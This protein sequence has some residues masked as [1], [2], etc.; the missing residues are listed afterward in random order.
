MK[1]TLFIFLV[2]LMA[3]AACDSNGDEPGKGKLPR[4][5]MEIYTGKQYLI[6]DN[7]GK[8]VYE[9]P[10]TYGIVN[11]TAEGKNWYGVLLSNSDSVYRVLKNGKPVFTTPYE[12]KSL[13][14][15]NGDI[16]T[17]QWDK[18][19]DFKYTEHYT[20]RIFKNESQLYEYDSEE[21][22]IYDLSVDHGDLIA[23]AWYYGKY[24]KPT[25]WINGN[26]YTLPINKDY[27]PI[28]HIVKNGKDT[29]AI[30][31]GYSNE[32]LYW[33]MNGETHP[34]PNGFSFYTGVHFTYPGQQIALV[35]GVP[36]MVG[37]INNKGLTMM[38]NGQEYQLNTQYYNVVRKVQRLGSDVYTLTTR[39]DYFPPDGNTRIFKGAEQIEI[40]S[41]VYIPN[42]RYPGNGCIYNQGGDTVKLTDFS[43][44]D[45]AVLDR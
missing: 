19:P 31:G 12:V 11:M 26:M 45:F 41:K 2:A 15:E 22:C 20:A 38:I 17:L 14:V 33:W 9:C 32:P 1:K 24:G 18:A 42:V 35:N 10:E 5:L 39:L 27:A 28:S 21:I 43:V 29:L 30:L 16:Y 3:L 6:Y 25:Y 34:L 40:N 13:C 37:Y 8:L 4:I 7:D 36:Y 23:K 44:Q